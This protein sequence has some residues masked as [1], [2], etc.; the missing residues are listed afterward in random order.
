[1]ATWGWADGAIVP[2][3][4]DEADQRAKIATMREGECPTPAL[5]EGLH[6]LRALGHQLTRQHRTQ[7]L[8]PR[9]GTLIA[10]TDAI[11]QHLRPGPR[12]PWVLESSSWDQ[13]M[14]A[15]RNAKKMCELT[16][17]RGV[18]VMVR[19]PQPKTKIKIP[20]AGGI[21]EGLQEEVH[22]IYKVMLI[23]PRP[24]RV[25][26]KISKHGTRRCYLDWKPVVIEPPKGK[27]YHIR[28]TPYTTVDAPDPDLFDFYGPD[29]IRV[30]DRIFRDTGKELSKQVDKWAAMFR[31]DGE[32][33]SASIVSSLGWIAAVAALIG[34]L[35]GLHG[36]RIIW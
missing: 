36:F 14:V 12:I 7:A 29:E 13:R 3:V 15:I 16:R 11:P 4:M 17:G 19:R 23:V 34:I 25:K 26:V 5:I 8:D 35:G 1:M 31:G 9:W 22:I 28:A 10:S 32:S 21:Q 30:F 2:I 18:L 27:L 6:R 24:V 20:A 33:A